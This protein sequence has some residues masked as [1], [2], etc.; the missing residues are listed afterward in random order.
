MTNI[1]LNLIRR[2][3]HRCLDGKYRKR[4]GFDVPNRPGLVNRV[5]LVR[6]ADGTL[7]KSETIGWHRLAVEAGAPG[8]TRGVYGH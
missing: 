3:Y 5:D 1:E 7:L 6:S 4:V 2:G 8:T